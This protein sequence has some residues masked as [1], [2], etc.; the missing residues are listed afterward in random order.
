MQACTHSY[1]T[2]RPVSYPRLDDSSCACVATCWTPDQRRSHV[3]CYP[4]EFDIYAVNFLCVTSFKFCFTHSWHRASDI[5]GQH[6]ILCLAGQSYASW[7]PHFHRHLS[8]TLFNVAATRWMEWFT[9]DVSFETLIA[10]GSTLD[11]AYIASKVFCM[12]SLPPA[13]SSIYGTR[14]TTRETRCRVHCLACNLRPYQKARHKT[15][16]TGIRRFLFKTRTLFYGS[17]EIL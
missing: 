15:S 4:R 5:G 8:L 3:C 7:L 11:G 6:H 12:A 14:L 9:R 16:S 10:R 1:W 17:N 2:F 13:S